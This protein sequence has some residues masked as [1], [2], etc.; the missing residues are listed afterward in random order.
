LLG[1][2]LVLGAAIVQSPADAQSIADFY[3]GKT[4]RMLAGYGP[5]TA[6][7][8]FVHMLARH[9][10]Q[11]IPGNPLIVPEDMPGAGSLTMTNY[12]YNAAPRDGTVFGSPLSTILSEPLFGNPLA[13]FDPRKFTWLGGL[14]S[15]TQL[16]FT[17]HTTGITTFEYA[18]THK[19]LMGSTGL[20]A[21]SNFM[22]LLLNKLFGTQF[23]PLIY[24]DSGVIGMAMENGELQ[25]YCFGL[26]SIETARPEWLTKHEINVLIQLALKP[27]PELKSA[28][29]VMDLAKD[30]ASREAL[31]LVL[32]DEQIERPV[33][34]PPDIPADRVEVLREA[35]DETVRDP[36]FIDE[37]K[38]SAIDTKNFIG[39][40]AAEEVFR[41]IYATPP[42]V[43]EMV[44][45][46]REGH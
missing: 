42:R 6:V 34:G 13:K 10:S 46:L 16:C 21:G 22:P 17:W 29:L 18:K 37:A 11:Y 19:I 36:T 4:I 14:G 31:T 1:A 28:P 12:L 5:G 39:G 33:I 26:Y 24:P 20:S 44:R 25:G 3:K 30:D 38:A 35:F 45:A 41:R 43:V 32:A 27:A 7:D 9:M 23:E 15:E 8:I 2:A 40:K